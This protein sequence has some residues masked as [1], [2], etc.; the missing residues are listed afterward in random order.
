MVC[1]GISQED[2]HVVGTIQYT[3]SR[4][5]DRIKVEEKA[6]WSVQATPFLGLTGSGITRI[7]VTEAGRTKLNGGG[8]MWVALFHWKGG[9]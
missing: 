2:W 8:H 6:S 9:V 5:G 7:K 1:E 3:K 4:G